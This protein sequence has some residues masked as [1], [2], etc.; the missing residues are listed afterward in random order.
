MPLQIGITGGIGT[1]K[2][3]VCRIF[4]LLGA[5]VYDADS[6]AKWL[7]SN[8]DSLKA[9]VAK[10]FGAE[11]YLPDG[12][13]NRAY[14]AAR[15][16]NQGNQVEKLNSLVHPRMGE[17]YRRWLSQYNAKP[18]VLK[19]AALLF[20]SGSYKT[21]DKII[22]V[23]TPLDL[24][25]QRIKQ[26]DPQRSEKEILAIIAKQL[27]EQEKIMRADWLIH[28]DEKHPVI[29]QVL[30]LHTSVMQTLS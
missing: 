19:E 25:L 16:F 28:N 15:V 23:T 8:D 27:D 10:A 2:S 17:D 29:N 14:L 26:R 13:L 6:R 1:G 22:V 21:L 18:Y 20:E 7:L 5:P 24:R 3:L 11:S 4:A 30:D 12:T 9:S